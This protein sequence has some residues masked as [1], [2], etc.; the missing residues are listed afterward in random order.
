MKRST[1]PVDVAD[2]LLELVEVFH[3]GSLSD[4]VLATLEK[5]RH[6]AGLEDGAVAL[7]DGEHGWRVAASSSPF[8]HHMQVSRL[9]RHSS[10]GRQAEELRSSVAVEL[11]P[12]DGAFEGSV[13]ALFNDGYRFEYAF[14]MR[15]GSE[16]LGAVI[17]L[18][19]SEISFGEMELR[20]L[21]VMADVAGQML[22]TSHDLEESRR[23][24][25]QLQSALDSRVVI[26][27]AKGVIA[28]RSGVGIGEAFLVL[29]RAARDAR[30]PMADVA[31]RIV[32]GA[33][34]V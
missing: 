1:D 12:D 9:A 31:A 8:V 27:Q 29:R 21:Q 7:V 34:P 17:L 20:I 26:E 23:L 32:G 4:R 19:K 28:A 6:A 22:A 3:E 14:P 2:G 11:R 24:A 13:L 5:C 33:A 25:G 10:A 16:M 30:Q 15:L 18:D